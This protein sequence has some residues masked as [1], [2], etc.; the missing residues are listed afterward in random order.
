MTACKEILH[1]KRPELLTIYTEKY[2]IGNHSS[3][4]KNLALYQGEFLEIIPLS[5]EHL[6]NGGPCSRDNFYKHSLN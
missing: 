5:R 6:Y 2:K 4:D 1:K 3:C